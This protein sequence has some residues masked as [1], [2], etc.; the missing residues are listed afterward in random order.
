MLE[1]ALAGSLGDS[2][3]YRTIQ[4]A[5]QLCPEEGAIIGRLLAGYGE[6]E[7]DL[8]LCVAATLDDDVDTAFRIMFR[9]RGESQ[10]IEIADAFIQQHYSAG[11]RSE[12]GE[13]L[14]A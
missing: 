7:V 4:R 3:Q 8:A 9:L 14:G 2:G 13:A 6:L 12:Y 10:R 11:L 1:E 5:F